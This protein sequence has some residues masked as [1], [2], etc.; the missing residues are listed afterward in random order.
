MPTFTNRATLTYNG[1]ATDSNTVVG[2]IIETLTIA[3]NAQTDTY[4]A[5]SVVTYVVSLVNSGNTSFTGLTVT[6]N[7]G[8]YSF[9]GQTLYPLNYVDGSLLYYV[10]GV[11][12]ATPTV[13]AGPPLTVTGISVPSGGN[14]ILIYN[15]EVGN[16]APLGA[17]STIVN[18]ATVSGQGLAEPISASETIN[19]S[20][21]PDLAITKALSPTSV[22]ENGEITYTFVI[23]NYGNTA[24]V[25]TDNLAVNDVF[26]PILAITSVTLDGTPIAVGT[27]YTYDGVTGAFSTVQ[28]VITVPA[29]TFI[30]E[31]D[32]TY[33]T[34]PG[35]ATL[36]VTGTV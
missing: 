19:T 14:A 27:G 17:D 6:D 20:D 1:G 34:V 26:D 33:T 23:S 9:D 10:N 24:A 12:Q 2:N 29:A 5:G 15:A 13:T 35:T 30:Q 32:G 18:T 7:L 8:A 28:G 16:T 3:K 22:A 21:A 31:P 36:V 11:L 4:T 25:A